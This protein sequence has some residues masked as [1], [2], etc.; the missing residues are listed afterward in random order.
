MQVIEHS[1]DLRGY[2]EVGTCCSG[3]LPPTVSNLDLESS[4]EN[5]KALLFFVTK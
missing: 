2:N 1:D 5:N 4:P 3:K